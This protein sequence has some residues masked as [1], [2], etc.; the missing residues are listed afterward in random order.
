MCQ[1]IKGN[2]KGRVQLGNESDDPR[3]AAAQE[4]KT[5]AQEAPE[6]MH[7]SSSVYML[8]YRKES[9]L[10]ELEALD[11]ACTV[12]KALEDAV[13]AENAAFAADIQQSIAVQ[14]KKEEELKQKCAS[15]LD[16]WHSLA[17][18]P[19]TPDSQ[20]EFVPTSW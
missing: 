18:E 13:A 14:E 2:A 12:S 5:K 1:E 9:S 3:K 6:G 10:Q 11:V 19:G 20:L 7:D 17:P 4:K 15:V 16:L 8:M